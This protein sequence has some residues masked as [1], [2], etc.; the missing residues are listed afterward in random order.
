MMHIKE[1]SKLQTESP[2][3]ALCCNNCHLDWQLSFLPGVQP[4]FFSQESN[5]DCL[6]NNL[7][8]ILGL[9]SFSGHMVPEVQASHGNVL[10][11]RLTT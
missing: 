9:D 11:Q 10:N 4:G 5:V 1:I 7:L 2:L 8:H 3:A 6:H